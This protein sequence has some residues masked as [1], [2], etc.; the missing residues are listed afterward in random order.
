VPTPAI[1][2]LIPIVLA[3]LAIAGAWLYAVRT[4]AR[5]A[6]VAYIS[7]QLK[8]LYGPLFALSYASETAWE[9]FRRHYRPGRAFFDP[10]NPPTQAEIDEWVRWMRVVFAPMNEKMVNIVVEHAELIEGKMPTSFLELIAHVEGY[11]AV[12]DKW[13]RGDFSEFN[14]VISFPREFNSQVRNTFEILNERQK[15]LL[16]RG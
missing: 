3:L 2:P 13:A 10:D 14:S 16:R 6:R 9:N 4:D 5:R 1:I 7:A 11:K 8:H 12:L 15:A